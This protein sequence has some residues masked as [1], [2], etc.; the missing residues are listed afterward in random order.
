MYLN[1][2]A[3]MQIFGNEFM[4]LFIYFELWRYFNILS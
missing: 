4:Y 1:I 3:F 2:Y